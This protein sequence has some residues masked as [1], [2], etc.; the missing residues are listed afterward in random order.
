MKQVI[1]TILISALII[2]VSQAQFAGGSGT[3]E[4]PYQI[5]TLEQL[6]EIRNHLD[7]HFIQTADIDASDTQNWNNG[8]GFKPIGDDTT[9]FEGSYDGFGYKISN[10][11]IN[12][13]FGF[14]NEIYVGLFGYAKGSEIKSISLE[15]VSI[16]G[17]LFVG[18]IAGRFEGIMS[19]SYSF[20]TV[21]GDSA[22]G[23]LIGSI[24][25][26][27]DEIS[28]Y[29]TNSYS[30]GT[31]S[32]NGAGGLIG[33][34]YS[35]LISNS[36]A[37]NQINGLFVI[38]G[39]V[40]FNGGEIIQSYSTGNVGDASAST[41]AGGVAGVNSG[42]ISDSYATGNV[43]GNRK[44]GG[45]VGRNHNQGV[46]VNSFTSGDVL[47][48]FN[49]DTGGFAGIDGGNISSS[50]WDVEVSGQAEGIGSRTPTY[51]RIT[52]TSNNGLLGL[53]TVQMT[54]VNA[55]EYMNALDFEN[56]WYLTEDYPALQ[57]QDVDP[58]APPDPDLPATVELYLPAEDDINVSVITT[59]IWQQAQYARDFHLQ[60][61]LDNSFDDVIIDK[62][63][64]GDTLLVVSDPLN[65]NTHYFWRV[66][67]VNLAGK[68]EWSQTWSFFTEYA[69]EQPDLVSPDDGLL[70][71]H[72]PTTF[73]WKPVDGAL[74]YVLEIAKDP[75]FETVFSIE[76]GQSKA[77]QSAES[78]EVLSKSWSV[79][80][81]VETLD[82]STQYFW[83]VR[84]TNEQGTSDWSETRSITTI[85][86]PITAPVVLSSPADETEDM[87]FPVTLEW[88]A[89]ER[90]DHYEVQLSKDEH[91]LDRRVMEAIDDTSVL[92]TH[93][94]D[95]TRYY[96]R[97]RATVD[98]QK[99]AWS[100][101]W[102]F[103]TELRVPDVPVWNPED[104]QKD[105]E[106]TPLLV[107][108]A[109]ERAEMYDLQLGENADFSEILIEVFEISQTEYQVTDELDK[110]LTYYWRVRAGN[111]SGY[112]D[113]SDP[114]SFTTEMPTGV[115]AD[116]LPVAFM[117]VEGHY[118]SPPVVTNVPHPMVINIPQGVVITIPHLWSIAFLILRIDSY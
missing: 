31:V 10:L 35:G 105:V 113:W 65:Y 37:G 78:K 25:D 20:G 69:L 46:I 36:F 45:F 52:G 57:W 56:T 30:N 7:K 74:D 106:T 111:R 85:D 3:D 38:G 40:G 103:A 75:E 76:S 41:L 80:Q 92:L 115:H 16:E 88:E 24:G 67:G 55:F 18:G 29:I 28:T 33:T 44:L 86:A 99:T 54:G 63:Q 13:R 110:G 109:S 97:V 94:S 26:F 21:I 19:D 98:N 1:L 51:Q 116:E 60:I 70:D 34:N 89:F 68:G 87:P 108:G 50:Y 61:A 112:S 23:G 9:K 96:W 43:S 53:T 6:Q 59:F 107:W 64:V 77:T 62:E 48:D 15:N 84:A 27:S 14:G 42:S 104:G 71:T 83:R 5:E 66:R 91:F 58:I 93:L 118:H 49:S 22:V 100:E 102:T 11:T 73:Y 47:S 114:L 4:D 82:Y 72:I 12:R 101:V 90:A 17:G 32:G 2:S 8:Q 39:L 95:T 117:L 79:S 81:T